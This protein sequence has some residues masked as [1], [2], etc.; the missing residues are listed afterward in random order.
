MDTGT[1]LV[2]CRANLIRSPVAA[3]LLRRALDARTDVEVVSA[4]L[5][6]E[7]GLPADEDAIA[8]AAQV[9]VDL[10]DHRSRP[11]TAD[12]VAASAL[13]VTMTEEQRSTLVRILPAAVP[14]TFTLLE[15]VRLAGSGSGEGV[16]LNGDL[17]DVAALAHR[18]R[19]LELGPGAPEDVPD[20]V[21]RGPEELR[22]VVARLVRACDR[23]TGAAAGGRAVSPASGPTGGSP[24][25]TPP[26]RA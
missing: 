11:V 3:G 5:R 7:P 13:V 1:L 6:A 12:L 8:L 20:P 25:P 22:A 14:R 24:A 17:A 4:G 15:L 10:A 2:V 16:P 23:L 26:P 21:G 18:R 9:G 19:P